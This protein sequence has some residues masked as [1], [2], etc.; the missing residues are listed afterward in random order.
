VAILTWRGDFSIQQATA[1][2]R[3]AA[4]EVPT[5]EPLEPRRH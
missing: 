5:R 1:E 2:L 3:D 4:G